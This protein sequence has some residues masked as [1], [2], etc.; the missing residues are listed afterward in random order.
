MSPVAK[1]DPSNEKIEE[2]ITNLRRFVDYI[3]LEYPIEVIVNKYLEGKDDDE[4]EIFIPQYQRN[5]VW[6]DSRQS[7]FIESLFLGLPIPFLFLADVA[8]DNDGRVEVVD[9]SQRI[10]TLAN[11]IEGGLELV[12][13][14]KLDALNGSV[15]TDL[16]KPRQ[17]R[18]LRTN[19]KTIVLTE[20]ADET[21]RQDIF[22]R[23]NTGSDTLRPME[24]RKGAMAGRFNDFIKSETQNKLFQ[25]LAPVSKRLANRQEKEELVLRFFAY[26]DSADNF[27]HIVSKFMDEY[28]QKM[29]DSSFDEVRYKAIF[30][31]ML[32]FI[33]ETIPN[34]F[35]KS[36]NA[37]S[38]PRVR[39]ETL[40]VGAARALK[41]KPNL[42]CKD[43]TWIDSDEFKKHT[44]SD[45]SNSRTKLHARINYT[46]NKFLGK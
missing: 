1:T 18:F 10:R 43:I 31:N 28:L 5:F 3:T 37:K 19:I 9:G 4:N 41:I 2:Q 36:P 35:K 46:Q 11:Y 7:K 38:T 21:T 6:D 42:V 20:K 27:D 34:G 44:R 17:M 22:E 40:A 25:K 45:G 32:N 29:N 13:L 14:K 8:G 39:F 12:E 24:V 23:I 26:F 33:D 16:S 30:E 15:F